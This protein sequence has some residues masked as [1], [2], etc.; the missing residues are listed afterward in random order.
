MRKINNHNFKNLVYLCSKGQK[1]SL[2]VFSKVR[3]KAL[4]CLKERNSNPSCAVSST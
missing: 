4:H 1:A 3:L 2:N